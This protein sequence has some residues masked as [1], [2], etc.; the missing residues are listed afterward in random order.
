MVALAQTD[1]RG[2]V[3]VSRSE[4]VTVLSALFALLKYERCPE[5]RIDDFMSAS[6]KL[7]AAFDIP[8]TFG[9]G[10]MKVGE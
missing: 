6:K 5:E 4:A 3:F 1:D 10:E 8:V 7:G 9:C 2:V